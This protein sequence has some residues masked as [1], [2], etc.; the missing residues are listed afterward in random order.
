MLAPLAR[1]DQ[2]DQ[3][4]P[5]DLLDQRAQLVKLVLKDPLVL[6]AQPGRPETL[7]PQDLLVLKVFKAIT[8]RQVLKVSKEFKAHRVI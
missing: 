7:A 8:G 2:L 6:P 3:R 4:A 5:K 1:Q